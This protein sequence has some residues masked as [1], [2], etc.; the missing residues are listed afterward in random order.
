[1]RFAFV[2]TNLPS[3]APASLRKMPDKDVT[4]IKISG[5]SEKGAA[6][7]YKKNG[8]G[9]QLESSSA[10]IGKPSLIG[11]IYT[12]SIESF[13]CN[14]KNAFS[15]HSITTKVHKSRVEQLMIRMGQLI[16]ARQECNQVYTNSL[17]YLSSID[18]SSSKLAESPNMAAD[19]N[20]LS[21]ASKSLAIQN[22]ELQKFSC[23]M[24][25]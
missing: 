16:P 24:I 13:E 25:Y 23:P 9:W 3:G 12:D 22:R 15:K 7:F 18:T 20:V 19:I 2:N 4:A 1:M 10:Y 5:N 17:P 14:M 11:A 6:E 21:S 8:D